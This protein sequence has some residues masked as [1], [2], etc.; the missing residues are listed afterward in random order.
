MSGQ[1]LDVRRSWRALRRHRRIV[2][3]SAL[4]GM[5]GGVL[6]GALFPPMHTAT[7]LILLPPPAVSTT[8]TVPTTHGIDTQVLVAV[9]EPVLT[10]AGENLDPPLDTET[11]RERVE[12]AA[13]TDDVLE[14]N[15]RG[16][17]AAQAITLTNAV[18]EVYLVYAT[19][20]QNLPDDL[21]IRDGARVL[22]KA[23]SA[24]GGSGILHFGIFAVL[25]IVVGG[26]A[27]SVG[28]LIGTHRD[29]RLHLRDE[30]ANSVG[31]PVL[32]SVSSLRARSASD[33]ANLLER[34]R[35]SAVD[36]WS[37][38]RLLRSLDVGPTHDDDDA[39][40]PRGTVS[41]AVITFSDDEKAATLGP[42][43]A[44]YARSAG[45]STSLVVDVTVAAAHA[46]LGEPPN[47]PAVAAG[48]KPARNGKN[49]HADDDLDLR[50]SM[51]VVDRSD[52]QLAE[53]HRSDKTIVGISSGAV[54]AEDLARLAVLAAADHRELDGLVV[55]DP[56]PTDRTAGRVPHT[57]RAGE[58]RLRTTFT[59]PARKAAP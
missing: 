59:G 2:A 31:I 11:V 5:A 45:I 15:G 14:I 29:R 58:T 7:S 38:L 24:S 47:D 54:T 36:G 57:T 17:S 32:A 49:H 46:L 40:T 9:S 16:T 56:D 33:W 27:G 51:I 53:A 6:L 42:Q 4:A 30:M 39:G 41:I 28:V 48:T 13:V 44:A 23:T 55:L 35:P 1:E 25:G 50:I 20:E 19:T 43:L 18:A 12:V 8:E 26:L 34:Y 21:G 22:Q 3:A 10:S 52:P 37:I